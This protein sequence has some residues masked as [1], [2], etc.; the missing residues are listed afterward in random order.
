MEEGTL[1]CTMCGG[2]MHPV[3]GAYA[4]E[5]ELCGYRLHPKP[6]HA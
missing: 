5:C 2:A 1:R 6:T 4:Y 3:H